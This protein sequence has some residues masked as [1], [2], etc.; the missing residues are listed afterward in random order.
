MKSVSICCWSG[1][2]VGGYLGPYFF[3]RTCTGESYLNMLRNDI[4][5]ELRR[6]GLLETA[7]FQQDGAP[8]HWSREVR[9]YLTMTFGDRW[10]GRG[11]PTAWPA[12]SPDLT[13]PDF[14]LWGHLKQQVYAGRPLNL[15]HLRALIV[16]R[17]D[18]IPRRMFR[19]SCNQNLIG[20]MEEC[21][22][23]GGGHIKH[24]FG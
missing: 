2:Y 11:G 18:E 15:E 23:V 7:V 22:R 1:V 4:V 14:F 6:K 17:F 8:P 5:P 19:D 21:V 3:E 20:R 13:P 12:R 10:I 9:D 24:R 16:A